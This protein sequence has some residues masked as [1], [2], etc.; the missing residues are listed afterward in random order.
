MINQDR[1]ELRQAYFDAWEKF[2]A[3]KPLEP[4]EDEIVKAL[5]EHP[6]YQSLIE[7]HEIDGDKEFTAE[8]GEVNPYL[9]L[10]L[11]IATREQVSTDR[12]KG[13]AKIYK[14]LKA[15]VGAHDADHAIMG[16]LADS[17][18]RMYHQQEEFDEKVYIDELKTLL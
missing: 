9:H 6:E 2:K 17:L 8:S 14:K 16:V 4:L 11:H 5:C 3:Q 7:N 18:W 13:I 10:G 12:P 15:K 1:R